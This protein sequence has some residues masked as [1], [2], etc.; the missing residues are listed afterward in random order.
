MDEIDTKCMRPHFA[1]IADVARALSM[2]GVLRVLVALRDGPLPAR[3]LCPLLHVLPDELSLVLDQLR[4]TGLVRVDEA[5]GCWLGPRVS[6]TDDAE[7]LNIT[8][9]VEGGS[10]IA[11]RARPEQFR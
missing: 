7:F 11:L 4:G 2:Q 5:L 6:V 9:N 3:D 1:K 8:V 10:S